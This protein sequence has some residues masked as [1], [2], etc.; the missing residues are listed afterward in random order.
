MMTSNIDTDDGLVNGVM[1][2]LIR[3]IE[4]TKPLSQPQTV[5]VKFDNNKVGANW[6]RSHPQPADL[7]ND[8]VIVHPHTETIILLGKKYTRHQF[9]LRLSWACTIHKVQGMT[10]PQ[11]VVSLDRIFKPGMAYVAL[12]RV[13][14][15][16]GLYLQ[17]CEQKYI[18]CDKTAR[19]NLQSMPTLDLT[20]EL[21]VLK[22]SNL[23]TVIMVQNVQGLS[24]KYKDIIANPEIMQSD[25]LGFSETW[26]SDNQF[27]D[28]PGLKCES[29]IRHQKQRGGVAIYIKNDLNYQRL[30]VNIE[31]LEHV[32]ISLPT[33][34]LT[35]CILY[36]PQ[37]VKK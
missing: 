34:D 20:L 5:C 28:I 8:I 16:S 31:H 9:P 10:V 32:A 18:Y 1:G 36:R 2:T 3:V 35:V 4:G 21:P 19:I 29:Y 33:L 23:G 7:S 6:R 17:D 12:S 25:I 14:S 37:T 13:T 26:L 27:I 30:H 24:S 15:L 22:L 11:I